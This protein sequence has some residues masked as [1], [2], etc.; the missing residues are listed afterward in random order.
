MV[1]KEQLKKIRQHLQE[2]TGLKS[3]VDFNYGHV[4]IRLDSFALTPMEL[5]D[6]FYY[7]ENKLDDF[8]FTPKLQIIND[9]VRMCLGIRIPH[10]LID[11]KF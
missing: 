2:H 5:N 10:Y 9:G 6:L 7:M 8:L 1:T 4:N 11:K 3:M